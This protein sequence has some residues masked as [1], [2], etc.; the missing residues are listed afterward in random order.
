MIYIYI[1]IAHRY[2][3]ILCLNSEARRSGRT[4]VLAA[5]CRACRRTQGLQK[6]LESM[7]N[8]ERSWW[9]SI[10]CAYSPYGRSSWKDS[11][12]PGHKKPLKAEI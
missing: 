4:P 3:I 9:S 10:S 8:E 1:C 5:S 7:G 2:W 12:W 6:A 11:A